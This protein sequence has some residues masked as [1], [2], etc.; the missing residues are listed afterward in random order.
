[1]CGA[2]TVLAEGALMAMDVA[3]GLLRC[4]ARERFGFRGWR[5]HDR[6]LWTS[7]VDEARR[8]RDAGRSRR[9]RLAGSD[10]DGSAL[11]SSRANLAAAGAP[12][13]ALERVDVGDAR[14][15]SGA[16]TG[17]IATNAPYGERMGSAARLPAVYR[18]LGAAV[19][20]RF[21]GWTLALLT[22][23]AALAGEVR[24]R[25]FRRNAL[26]NGSIRCELLQYRVGERPAELSPPT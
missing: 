16:T 5:G 9:P 18:R 15:P 21:S 22:A 19:K 4:G 1:M 23:D 20:E 6:D 25:A 13:V 14:P 12:E 8:R 3:P 24:M 11:E 2:G 10:V 26:W 17:L 7:L